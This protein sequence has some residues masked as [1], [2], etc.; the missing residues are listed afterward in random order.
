M[1]PPPRILAKDS[2]LVP[3]DC[4]VA[5]NPPSLQS[6]ALAPPLVSTIHRREYNTAHTCGQ[7]NVFIH[8]KRLL[9]L[10]NRG[11]VRLASPLTGP[12]PAKFLVE[13]RDGVAH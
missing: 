8:V 3:S 11:A 12:C 5:S 6:Q 7:A 2:G 10:K 13:P 9:F 4:K 1:A